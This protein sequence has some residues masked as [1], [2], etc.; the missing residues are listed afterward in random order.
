MNY[1]IRYQPIKTEEAKKELS[2]TMKVV[3]SERNQNPEYITNLHNGIANRDNSYQAEN[4]ARPEVK[5]K[6]SKSLKGVPK[7]EAAKKKYREVKTNKPGDN[8]SVARGMA[9]YAAGQ[10]IYGSGIRPA[11]YSP[12]FAINDFTY[13]DTNGLTYFN[14]QYLGASPTT[15]PIER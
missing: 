3:A 13:A 5:A 15:Y 14:T 6:I 7:S 11:Q 2:K 10:G 4:N 1:D 9:T 8:A 12:D